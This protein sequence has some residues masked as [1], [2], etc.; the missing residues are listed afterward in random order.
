ME[1]SL[2]NLVDDVLY[3]ILCHLDSEPRRNLWKTNKT[4]ML[5]IGKWIIFGRDH[6]SEWV[7]ETIIS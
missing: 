2:S 1:Y 4:I 6:R 5:K 3:L 7:Y